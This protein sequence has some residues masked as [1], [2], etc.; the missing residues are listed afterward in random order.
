MMCSESLR[1]RET[2]VC[3]VDD[4]LGDVL[5]M[6]LGSVLGDVLVAP[7]NDPDGGLDV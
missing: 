1:C 5:G 7:G 6:P 2:P 4:A 3:F